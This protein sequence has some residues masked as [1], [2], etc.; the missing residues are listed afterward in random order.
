ML[1]FFKTVCYIPLYNGLIFLI[2]VIPGHSVAVAVV[3][4]TALIKLLLFPLSYRATKFQLEM[5]AHEQ[6]INRIKEQY[7]NDKQAQGA[8]VL[9]FYR[10]KGINPFAGILPTLIQIP[11]IISLYYIFFRGGLPLVDTSVLYSWVSVPTPSMLILGIDIGAKSMVLAV[12][13]AL[14]QFWQ[15]KLMTPPA[16][17]ASDG[18]SLARDMARGMQF[19]MVYVLP[20]FMGFVAYHASA[21]VALYFVTSNLFS[22]GQ[23]IVVRRKLKRGVHPTHNQT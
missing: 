19:Q 8:A 2:G 3:V 22:V 16:A 21:A 1:A 6:E 18:P 12:L 4:F 17:P 23:E 13:A 11:L 20:V 15:A 9:A 14:T 5:R 7:K 10:E